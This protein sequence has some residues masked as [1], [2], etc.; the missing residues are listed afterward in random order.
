VLKESMQPAGRNGLHK[1]DEHADDTGHIDIDPQAG[2]VTTDHSDDHS[3][4]TNN[5][6]NGKI[7]QPGNDHHGHAKRDHSLQRVGAQDVH[8]VCPG[9]KTVRAKRQSDDENNQAKLNNM[10]QQKNLDLLSVKR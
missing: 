5:G 3:G 9:H 2:Q 10:V 4:Q 6:T 1:A 8:P 7:D